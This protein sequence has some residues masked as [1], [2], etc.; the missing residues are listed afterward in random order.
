LVAAE[1]CSLQYVGQLEPHHADF[2]T[3]FDFTLSQSVQSALPDLVGSTIFPVVHNG[4]LPALVDRL[5][6][7]LHA[8]VD[9]QIDPQRKTLAAIV[10]LANSPS[11]VES[12]MV[13]DLAAG[14]L[15]SPNPIDLRDVLHSARELLEENDGVDLVLNDV[16][17]LATHGSATAQA[18][19]GLQ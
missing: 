8:L 14:A 19:T 17:S 4:S 1:T 13:T 12:A 5:G 3:S 11:L 18:C 7:G 15:A 9:D 6:Q 2:V 16:M 10:D